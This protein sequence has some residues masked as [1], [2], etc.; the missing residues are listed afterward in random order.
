GIARRPLVD[1]V[2]RGLEPGRK[3]V[4]LGVGGLLLLVVGRHGARLDLLHGREPH[5]LTTREIG[6]GPGGG[7]VD[8][9]LLLLG[10]V[11]AETVR[12]EER[13]DLSVELAIP[14][15]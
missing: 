7:D 4:A 12:L 8:L 1:A 6:F 10:A 9:R 13:A 3:L 5:R 14:R 11:A 2:H 15:G